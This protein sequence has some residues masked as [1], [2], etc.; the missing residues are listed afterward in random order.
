MSEATTHQDHGWGA[1]YVV[2]NAL[3]FL[4]VVTVSTLR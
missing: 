3:I 1:Y 4:T 2:F